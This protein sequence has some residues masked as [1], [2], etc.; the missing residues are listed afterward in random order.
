MTLPRNA[1]LDSEPLLGAANPR[2]LSCPTAPTSAAS[3]AIELATSVGLDLDPWQRLVLDKALQERADGK[4][5]AFEVGLCVPRQNGKGSILEALELSSLLLFDVELIV[6]SAHEF[7]TSKEAMR[8]LEFLLGESGETFKT[9]NAHGQ[10][11]FELPRSEK[12]PRGARIFFQTRTKSGGRG[13]SGDLVILDE[14]MILGSDAIGALMPTLAA[15]RNPQIWYTGS[16]VDQMIHD[17][18]YV[19]AGVRKRAMDGDSPRL[20][21]MEW[22]AEDTDVRSHP[23]TWSKANPGMGHRISP[24]YITDEFDAMRHSPKIFDVER[25]GLGDWP[26]ISAAERPP[27]DTEAWQGMADTSAQ[28]FG[29]RALGLH[30]SRDGKTWSLG[31]AQY[32]RDNRVH[33]EI[34]YNRGATNTDIVDY[35]V[36]VITDWNPDALVIDQRSP[37]AVLKPYLI[38]AGVEPVMTN[39]SDLALAC[40]GLLDAVDD[41]QLSH[42][43]QQV[44]NEAVMT[45]RKRDMPSGFT[46]DDEFSAPA[47]MAITL[48]HYGLLTYGKQPVAGSTPLMATETDRNSRSEHEFDIFSASF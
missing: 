11:G 19:F 32:T 13:L 38:D 16:A 7:K 45:A 33:V 31:A 8:R 35:I 6:H 46:W 20:C 37:A 29:A 24:E 21:Y 28:L 17:K 14:A 30:R 40:R 9:V 5:S 10:E 48:A 34:G 4:W 47:L 23:I 18:G 44:L 27:F 15:R 39:S 26:T 42:S 43:D 36:S 2:I 12:R 41:D 1:L 22:S 3:E 25:L